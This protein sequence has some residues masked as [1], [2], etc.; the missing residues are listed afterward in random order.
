M[1]PGDG[2]RRGRSKEHGASKT[3]TIPRQA[4]AAGPA[5]P[6]GG[7]SPRRSRRSAPPG[8]GSVR[9][10]RGMAGNVGDCAQGAWGIGRH[11]A[12][13]RRGRSP[14]S[15]RL[16]HPRAAG[17]APG[18]RGARW[19]GRR[20]ARARSGIDQ[21]CIRRRRPGLAGALMGANVRAGA[22][23]AASWARCARAEDLAAG[24]RPC[25]YPTP[26][27]N[28]RIS[29]HA[30]TDFRSPRSGAEC[31]GARRT[32]PWPPRASSPS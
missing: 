3:Q 1:G 28:I 21:W 17:S 5:P 4:G 2:R 11:D 30:P 8:G 27:P 32:E 24:L 22:R 23:H 7:A 31:M 25:H 13:G 9:R 15:R 18:R 16:A 12:T 19:R 26:F 10:V 6:A 29:G 20:A 14:A